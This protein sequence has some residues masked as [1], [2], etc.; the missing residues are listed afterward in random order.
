M[1][2][3]DKDLFEQAMADV[4]PLKQAAPVVFLAPKAVRTAPG[5]ICAA[6][7]TNNFLTTSFL[8]IIPCDIPLEYKQDG[9]QQG[10]LD[11]LHHGGYPPQASVNLTRMTVE[12][13]RQ[14]LFIFIKHM[15]QQQL[16]TLLIIHGKGRHDNSH[17]NIIRSFVARWLRQFDEVQAYCRALGRHG[18]EGACYAVLKKSERARQ[19]TREQA[20]RR[21]HR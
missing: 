14:D 10:V 2:G 18:G 20:A 11:K 8:D 9:I 1:T 16:R 17:A 12:Q 13:S 7:D 15:R 4:T 5:L 19:N 3:S 21:G 6:D